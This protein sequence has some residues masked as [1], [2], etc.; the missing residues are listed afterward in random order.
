MVIW[1]AM[2]WSWSGDSQLGVSTQISVSAGLTPGHSLSGRVA[3]VLENSMKILHSTFL[4][5]TPSPQL[6]LQGDQPSTMKLK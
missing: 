5:L 6:E 2:T 4:N 1:S 3:T